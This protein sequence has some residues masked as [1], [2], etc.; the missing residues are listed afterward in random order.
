LKSPE[1]M[2]WTGLDWTGG[3]MFLVPAETREYTFVT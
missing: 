3:C 2:N 1:G